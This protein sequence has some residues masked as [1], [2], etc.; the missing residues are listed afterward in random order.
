M[1]SKHTNIIIIGSGFSG[2]GMAINLQKKGKNDFLILERSSEIGGTWRDNNYPGAACDVPSHLYSFSF[3]PNPNWTYM[4]SRHDEILDYNKHCVEKY[5]LSAKICL[6]TNIQKAV[7]DESKGVWSLVSED[8]SAYTCRILIG[9][10]GPL[11]KWEIPEYPGINSFENTMFHSSNWN[12]DIDLEGKKVAVIGT[13][14][15]AIQIVPEIADKVKE[16]YLFQRTAPW[17]IPRP[18]RKISKLEK[19]FFKTLPFTQKLI[20]KFLYWNNELVAYALTKRVSLMKYIQKIGEY[21]IRRGVK[22]ESLRSLLT[23]NYTMGCKRILLSNEYYPALDRKNV[24]VVVDPI[25]A[26]TSNAIQTKNKDLFEADV[27]VWATGFTASEHSAP[28]EILGLN[29]V[30]LNQKWAKGGQSYKGSAVNDFPNF[31]SII[32]PN[33]GVGHTSMIV[34]ME[35]QYVYI[36][37]AIEHLSKE[38]VKFLNVKL[39]AQEAFNR[40][41]QEKLQG[42]IWQKGGCSSWYQN[43]EGKNTTLW[44]DFTF[45]FAKTNR[46][47]DVEN[48][49]VVSL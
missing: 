19:W 45:N 31:F 21:N 32:G 4:F 44:P 8:G 3:E 33:T 15:S 46:H 29:G 49:D 5:N 6:N 30:S 28:F 1:S 16:L 2:I 36:L 13:G 24:T 47:F 9:A 11:N 20:R 10:T 34:M 43:S 14:A 37:E 40:N 23:P 38:G 48:Y 22:N 39:S 18:D 27:V 26:F 17:V 25:N 42:T 41:I 35:A 12:H 7:F